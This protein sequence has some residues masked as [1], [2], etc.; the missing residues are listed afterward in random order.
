MRN[1]AANKLRTIMIERGTYG[2]H[3]SRID[4]I[5]VAEMKCGIQNDDGAEARRCVSVYT[6]K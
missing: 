1:A 4:F 6:I 5:I 3:T 2:I